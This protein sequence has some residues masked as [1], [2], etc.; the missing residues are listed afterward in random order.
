MQQHRGL[1][2]VA[3]STSRV[4]TVVLFLTGGLVGVMAYYG[5]V[6]PVVWVLAV[7]LGVWLRDR[8]PRSDA[9]W[10]HVV[11]IAA[12]VGAGGLL[13]VVAYTGAFAWTPALT[14]ACL[15]ALAAAPES[16]A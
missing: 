15:V 5:T 8:V 14:G 12:L 16:A 2:G 10:R 11:T 9:A 1:T 6:A 3:L 13:G 4:P 7:L